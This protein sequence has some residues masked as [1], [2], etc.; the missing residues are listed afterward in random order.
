MHELRI[1]RTARACGLASAF[2]A[3]AVSAPVRAQA[4]AGGDSATTTVA[5]PALH[6]W[7]EAGL[8]VVGTGLVFSGHLTDVR[9][10][11]VPADG[12]DPLRLD[13]SL[14]RGAVGELDPGA[15]NLSNWTRNAAIAFPYAV[16]LATSP[17]GGRMGGLAR[18]AVVHGEAMLIS[19]G[20]I[21]LGK[22]LVGRA[23]PYAYVSSLARPK[24]SSYDVT[25][26]RTFDSMPSGHSATAWTGAAMG[27]TEYMLNR[28]VA[29]WWER[30][31][32]GFAGGALAGTTSALRV[33]A[34]QHFPSDVLAGAG[35]G[36][37]VG[38]TIPLLH[39][40]DRRIPS[41]KSWLQMTGGVL[42]GSLVGTLA[43]ERF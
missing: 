10:R 43:A 2:L 32:V 37:A 13:W 5:R 12:Y 33:E 23:R 3:L 26:Q 9:Y 30:A 41:L 20:L 29:P 18:T 22:N 27:L 1:S 14:D 17:G 11:A 42:V 31:A 24:G 4:A 15:S 39:R 16:S 8:S 38:V 7:R 6:V 19:G 25:Q 36:I 34:G 28:P 40:G 35:I 21:L